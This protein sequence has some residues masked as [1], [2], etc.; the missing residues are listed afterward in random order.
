MEQKLPGDGVV[1][2]GVGGVDHQIH[3]IQCKQL[4][5]AGEGLA[6]GVD[7]LGHPA[8]ELVRVHD[9]LDLIVGIV[10]TAEIDTVDVLSASSLADDGDV[11]LSHDGG[12]FAM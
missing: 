6:P 3:V 5:I 8:A 12:S 9:V 2:L 7:L 10:L 11:Q 4:L 1:H